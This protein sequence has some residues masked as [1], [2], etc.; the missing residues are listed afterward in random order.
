MLYM[1][2]LKIFVIL[3]L[4]FLPN[5]P[6]YSGVTPESSTEDRV[7]LMVTG[8]LRITGSVAVASTGS[9]VVRR[10]SKGV[11]RGSKGARGRRKSLKRERKLTFPPARR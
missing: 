11:R 3:F 4:R 8:M 6:R 10:E 9:K 5:I 7:S 1:K 2:A